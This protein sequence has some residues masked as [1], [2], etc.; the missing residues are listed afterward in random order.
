MSPDNIAW[1]LSS[2]NAKENLHERTLSSIEEE[3][4]VGE[5]K[6]RSRLEDGWQVHR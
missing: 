2:I 5:E 6:K 4:W 1:I 3:G